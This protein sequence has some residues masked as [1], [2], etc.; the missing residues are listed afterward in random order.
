MPDLQEAYRN[1]EENY[2]GD[3]SS[4]I[5]EMQDIAGGAVKDCGNAIKAY[6]QTK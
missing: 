6:W 5:H 3:F 4:D 1:I 2:L